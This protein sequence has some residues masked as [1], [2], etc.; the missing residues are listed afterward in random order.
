MLLHIKSQGI[1]RLLSHTITVIR[2]TDT[3]RTASDPLLYLKVKPNTWRMCEVK[4]SFKMNF[5]ESD[6]YSAVHY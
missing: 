2:A 5:K 3:L 1:R 4:F 6:I